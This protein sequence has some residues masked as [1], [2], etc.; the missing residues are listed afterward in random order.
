MRVPTALGYYTVSV[1]PLDNITYQDNPVEVLY[2]IVPSGGSNEII[3]PSM[4]AVILVD[5]DYNITVFNITAVVVT[6]NGKVHTLNSNGT[7]N[8]TPTEAGEYVVIV[9]AIDKSTGIND[10]SVS[11]SIVK[12]NATAPVIDSI[13]NTVVGHSVVINVTMHDD[14]TGKVIYGS[15]DK[16]YLR[17][18][19]YIYN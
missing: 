5:E 14:E 3:T 19:I 6:I 10:T 18:F 4:D 13:A 2:Q 11:Y 17:F 9:S 7:F 15:K 16:I 1:V 8:D 12:R